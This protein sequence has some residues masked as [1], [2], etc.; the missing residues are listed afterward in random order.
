MFLSLSLSLG[1]SSV[2]GCT[3]AIQQCTKNNVIL[4]KF[5]CAQ[6]NSVLKIDG[7]GRSYSNGQNI[8]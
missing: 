7:K 4:C 1:S 3:V 5:A 2:P 6:P 8:L